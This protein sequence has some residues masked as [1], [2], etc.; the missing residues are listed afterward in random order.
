MQ[1]TSG[2]DGCYI[3]GF[4]LFIVDRI[5]K[6]EITYEQTQQHYGIRGRS[7]ILTWHRK[8][9][10]LDWSATRQHFMSKSRETREQKIK[11]L[12]ERELED[13]RV[14]NPKANP[15]V[16][17]SERPQYLEKITR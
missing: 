15:I 10:K 4:K 14:R 7:T 8:H 1:P 17:S 6:G 9:G 3:L 2:D 13:E 5:E 12:V 11:G 16:I